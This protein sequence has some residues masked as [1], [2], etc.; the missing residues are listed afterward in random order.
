MKLTQTCGVVAENG[1]EKADMMIDTP[2]ASYSLATASAKIKQRKRIV[3]QAEA[4][5]VHREAG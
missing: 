5:G 2:S 4:E 1:K 3:F